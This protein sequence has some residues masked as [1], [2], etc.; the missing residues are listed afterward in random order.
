MASYE[1]RHYRVN[2]GL[3]APHG[4]RTSA[5]LVGLSMPLR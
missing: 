4:E 1:Q 3:V 2:L 5:L